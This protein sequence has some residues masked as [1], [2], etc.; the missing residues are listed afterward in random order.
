MNF[1]VIEL[2]TTDGTTANLVT[3]YNELKLAESAFYSICASA[4]VSMVDTHAVVLM[5]EN[6]VTLKN[7]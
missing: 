3:Q 5:N 2:Q 4:V 6:G 1:L 7:E